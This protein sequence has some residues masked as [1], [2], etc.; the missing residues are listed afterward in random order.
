MPYVIYNMVT[1]AKNIRQG[2][3]LSG[4]HRCLTLCLSAAKGRKLIDKAMDKTDNRIM[5]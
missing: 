2:S 3:E 4:I 1:E 5:E